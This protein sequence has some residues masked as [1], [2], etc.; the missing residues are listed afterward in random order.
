MPGPDPF[1]ARHVY[2]KIEAR[3]D[4][5]E[6][7]TAMVMAEQGDCRLLR[8]ASP[9]KLHFHSGIAKK[10]GVCLNACQGGLGHP[11]FEVKMRE[12]VPQSARLSEGGCDGYLGNAQ[13]EGANFLVGLP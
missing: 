1:L 2:C 12:K 4:L 7:A 8:E 6:V 3:Y 5:L 11:Y 10:G 13:I 9:K